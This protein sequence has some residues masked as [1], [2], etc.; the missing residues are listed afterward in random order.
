[1]DDFF[2]ACFVTG[3][4]LHAPTEAPKLDN[5]DVK[6]EKVEVMLA[7]AGLQEEPCK[8]PTVLGSEKDA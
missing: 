8:R 6:S 3:A 2:D 1:M 7:Q 5:F 4:K